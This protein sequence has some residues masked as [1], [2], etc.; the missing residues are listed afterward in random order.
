MAGRRLFEFNMHYILRLSSYRA[1]STLHLHYKNQC[2]NS[3][4][5]SNLTLLWESYETR[6]CIHA[7]L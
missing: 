5:G 4:Q 1:V 7:E 2:V 6:K 3:V